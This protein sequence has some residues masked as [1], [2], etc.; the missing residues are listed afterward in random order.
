MFRSFAATVG[1]VNSETENS[2]ASMSNPLFR[3]AIGSQTDVII[4]EDSSRL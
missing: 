3:S 4:A 1:V 2:D